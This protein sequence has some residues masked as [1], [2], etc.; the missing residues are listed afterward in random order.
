MQLRYTLFVLLIVI[1]VSQS[2]FAEEGLHYNV[3]NAVLRIPVPDGFKD[4]FSSNKELYTIRIAST[5]AGRR[6]LAFL[7]T[8]KELKTYQ[9]GR[10][11]YFNENITIQTQANELVVTSKKSFADLRK[12][13]RTQ[14][15]TMTAAAVSKAPD[16][17]AAL[18]QEI[19]RQLGSNVKLNLGEVVQL[20]VFKESD[21]SISFA[22]IST[23][24]SQS[25]A[26]DDVETAVTAQTIA[27]V[28]SKLL[29]LLTRLPYRGKADIAR[30]QE[31]SQTL[32]TK[33]IAAN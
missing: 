10:E 29:W 5:P 19:S 28:K 27:L 23:V 18:S 4:T 7:V 26:G 24:Q 20:G 6:L 15:N 17:A 3:G 12:Q 8:E 32:L 2:A 9:N 13:V 30:A 1:N 11:T 16:S 33:I 31:L 21:T 14:L 25:I 22:F